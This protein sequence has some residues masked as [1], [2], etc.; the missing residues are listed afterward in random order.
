MQGWGAGAA[1]SREFLAPWSQSR[2]H[3]KKT[4]ARAGAGAAW[5]KSKEPEPEPEP[6]K[7]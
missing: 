1:R 3:L 6:Q 4:G 7:N 2:S 5:K